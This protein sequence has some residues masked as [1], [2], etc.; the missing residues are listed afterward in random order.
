MAREHLHALST[1]LRAPGRRTVRPDSPPAGLDAMVNQ[2]TG[3]AFVLDHRRDV[4]AWNTLGARLITDFGALPAPDR[5]MVWLMLTD[6]KLGRLYP[7]WET[8]ARTQVGMLRRASDL[9]PDDARIRE[10]VARLR[11]GSE[12]FVRW[13]PLRE[14]REKTAGT[15]TLIHPSLGRITLPFQVWRPVAT[16]DVEMLVYY[17]TDA[18]TA[19]VFRELAEL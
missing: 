6:P 14:V 19:R 3:P 17:A 15:K 10:L 11:T 2:F 18:S 16:T 8:G 9:H 5:N 12:E 4:L 13:W 7:D 1:G